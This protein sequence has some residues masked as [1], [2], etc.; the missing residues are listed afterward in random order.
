MSASGEPNGSLEIPTA[1][2]Y[3]DPGLK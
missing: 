1:D 2:K 3:A